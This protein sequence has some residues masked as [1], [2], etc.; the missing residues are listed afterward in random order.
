MDKSKER[1]KRQA[2][3]VPVELPVH[4]GAGNA[5]TR[6]M[7][8]NGIYFE[9]EEP[10][11]AGSEVDFSVDLEHAS[12][13]GLLRLVCQGRIVRVEQRCGRLGIA[14]A[15]ESHRFEVVPDGVRKDVN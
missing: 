9:T 5:H 8:G 15:I 12:A 6:D 14:V 10:F 4:V 13:A 2:E 11:A 3:R 7:S 1:D